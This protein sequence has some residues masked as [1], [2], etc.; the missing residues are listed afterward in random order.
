MTDFLVWAWPH[1]WPGWDAVWPNIL[2]SVVWA[3]PGWLALRRRLRHLRR[4]VGGLHDR[5]AEHAA[6]LDALTAHL[7][8]PVGDDVPEKGGA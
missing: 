6:K 3:V 2:A 8:V 4:Q 5:H 7:N 1:L